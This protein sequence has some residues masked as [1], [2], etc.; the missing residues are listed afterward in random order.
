MEL[1]SQGAFLFAKGGLVMYPLLV[2]SIMVIAIAIERCVYLQTAHTDITALLSPLLKHVEQGDWT[3]GAKLCTETKGAAAAMLAQGLANPRQN[4]Q[5]LEQVFE[6]AAARAISRLRYRLT[7]LDTIVTLAPLLGLL[8]TVTGMIQSF[9]V[10]SIKAGQ[11]LAITGGVGEALVATA[12]GLCV[13]IIA[14]IAFSYLNQRIEAII[15]EMEEAA[16]AVAT[17]AIQGKPYEA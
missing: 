8:G 17:A 9:S 15:T 16:N 4:S 2:C 12:T 5:Q 7:Y 6:G 14:L 13:A 3:A 10:L 1:L 11:P